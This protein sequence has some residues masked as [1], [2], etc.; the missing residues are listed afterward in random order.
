VHNLDSRVRSGTQF[1][2]QNDVA[3]YIDWEN[4]KYSLWNKDSRVPNAT[5]LKEAASKFGRV[6]VARAYAN[7]QEHQHQLDPNDLYSAGIEHIYVPTR[8]Y[9]STDAV[10]TNNRRK[11]SVDVKLTVDA[12]DFCL[13][14]PNIHTFVLVTGDGDFIHLVNALRSRGREVVVIGCSW[15]TS[16][17]LTSMA[18]YFIPYDIEVDPIYDRVGEDN[19]ED[20]D[21][22]HAFKTLVEIMHDIRRRG[23]PNVFAQI[24]LLM[25]SRMRNF[26]ERHYGFSNFREFMK[27]AER[28]GLIKTYNVGLIDR[29]Y[30][31]DEQ[32]EVDVHTHMKGIPSNELSASGANTGYASSYPYKEDGRSML[33]KLIR[34][35]SELERNSPYMSFNFMVEN[36]AN[37]GILPISVSEI[38]TMLNIAIDDGIFKRETKTIYSKATNDYREISVFH[39]NRSH[40]LVIE[41]TE[42]DMVSSES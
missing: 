6:V 25:L 1:L 2:H 20:V 39:L 19:T 5:A 26:D 15:S 31:P 24:R 42:E 14:N 36:A 30:L 22:E 37:N 8:T 32:L 23:E 35:I 28:R 29:A 3:L 11:N 18:D 34:Y 9:T 10:K 16:W 13:S 4:I 38:A 33:I 17:Q 27:E 21:L 7:W 12:V 40:P 41:A